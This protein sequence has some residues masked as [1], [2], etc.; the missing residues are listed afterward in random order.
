MG[1]DETGPILLLRNRADLPAS[2]S[3]TF[4]TERNAS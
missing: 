3:V 2:H 1:P 4:R